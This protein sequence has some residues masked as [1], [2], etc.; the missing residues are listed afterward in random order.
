MRVDAPVAKE[1]PVAA[2]FFHEPQVHGGQHDLLAVGRGLG[3]ANSLGRQMTWA[4]AEAAR[5]IIVA[6]RRRFSTASLPTDIWISATLNLALVM[7]Q[8]VVM[9]S[10]GEDGSIGNEEGEAQV[11][12]Q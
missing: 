6:A 4:P 10:L 2:G 8:P 5:S 7:T 3:V 9:P 1:G 11:G 12:S